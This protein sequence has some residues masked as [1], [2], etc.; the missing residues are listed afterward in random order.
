MGLTGIAKETLQIIEAGHCLAP[1]G[2]QITLRQEI[3]RA[4]SGTVLYR[5]DDVAPDGTAALDP[6]TRSTGVITRLRWER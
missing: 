4:I 3:D 5:P 6:S 2:R 1:S